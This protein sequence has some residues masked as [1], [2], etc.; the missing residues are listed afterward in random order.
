MFEARAG[1]KLTL[2][3]YLL[4]PGSQAYVGTL[5]LMFGEK[6]HWRILSVTREVFVIDRCSQGTWYTAG[7]PYVLI[8]SL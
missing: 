5:G 7:T 8:N 6:A 4:R 1:L 3:L 2:Y